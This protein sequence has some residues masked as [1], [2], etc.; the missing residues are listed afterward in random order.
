M[1]GGYKMK[2]KRII[3]I[4]LLLLLI[5]LLCLFALAQAYPPLYPIIP[6]KIWI[7]VGHPYLTWDR[8][9]GGGGDDWATS[10]IQTTDGGYTV[11]GYTLS[12]GAGGEDF[13]VIKLDKQGNQV[14]DKTYGGGG[15]DW[16]TSLIQ[17]TY[18]VYAV[19]GYTLSKGAGGADFWVIELYYDQGKEVWDKT[20][21]GS[22]DDWATSLIQITRGWP[23]DSGYAVAGFT[24]SKGAGGADFWVIKLDVQGKEV[25]DKT[26][27][28]GGDDKAT[29][30]IQTTD[31]GYAV[32]GYTLSKGA[33]G[34]DFW[35]IKLDKQG[36]QVWDKT[37]GGGGDDWATS[38]IQTTDGGYAVTG[39]TESKGSGGKDFWVIKLDVQGKEVWD[40]TY[41]G[42]GDDWATSLIQTTDGGY[43]VT[44]YT[45]SKGSGGKDF[46]V[47][48]LDG[49]GKEVWDRTYGG[50]G[51][52][53]AWSL[54]QTTDGGYAVTGYTESKGSGGKDL[55]VIKLDEQ[56]NLK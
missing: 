2:Y 41:G 19:A 18:G 53:L 32:A 55:W 42:G 54:I 34:E 52:D 40:K 43:A 4:S 7:L 28:G 46:W 22:G 31:G 1:E 23:S 15:D 10:L 11:A 9:Y 56:G 14:W 27:G 25:W 29:S 24:Y 44:G 47:I 35:V 45:E 30:L 50:G 21:G 37:Y 3:F 16:A 49:Q 39:Y 6:P 26:Y 51:D 48:K 17:T 5:S 12:K 38:L 20:Y 36:N 8:T 13:W 33:G